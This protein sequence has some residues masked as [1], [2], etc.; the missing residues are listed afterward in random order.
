[1]AWRTKLIID[2]TVDASS[3]T[4]AQTRWENVLEKIKYQTPYVKVEV[5]LDT[6]WKLVEEEDSDD[7][8]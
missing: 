1:M 8:S 2:V 7:A 3:E 4:R 6:N 5:P